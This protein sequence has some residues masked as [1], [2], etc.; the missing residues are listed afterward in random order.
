MNEIPVDGVSYENAEF[1]RIVKS[2][3]YKIA[4]LK[5]VPEDV[6]I[7]YPKEKSQKGKTLTEGYRWFANNHATI[8]GGGMARGRN[9]V[10]IKAVLPDILEKDF[11]M[12]YNS[13]MYSKK[14]ENNHNNGKGNSGRNSKN[15]PSRNRNGKY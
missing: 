3:F 10:K 6:E 7:T 15:Y 12:E 2:E 11:S 5:S 9:D 4:G 13:K 1:G 14:S 8:S